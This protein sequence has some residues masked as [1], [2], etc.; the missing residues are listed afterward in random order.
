M[1]K[2]ETL[3]SKILMLIQKQLE[4]LKEMLVEKINHPNT[5]KVTLETILL[6]ISII[7]SNLERL[8]D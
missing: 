1:Q 7:R 5:K 8:E 6:T 2:T 4:L 3:D